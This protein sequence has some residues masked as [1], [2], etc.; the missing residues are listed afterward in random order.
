MT[1]MSFVK[2]SHRFLFLMLF[3]GIMVLSVRLNTLLA[4]ETQI[5]QGNIRIV[6]RE[7]SSVTQSHV[8]LGDISDIKANGFIKDVIEK[9][10]ISTSPKPGKI[11]LFSK[12]KIVSILRGQRYLPENIVIISPQQIY[13]KRLS[14]TI[15]K[16]T[17]TKFVDTR[18]RQFF[19]H[20]AYQLKILKVR[21]LNPY[22]QG[23]TQFRIDS[24]EM[25]DRNGKLSF[26]IDV[27]IDG[28]KE[29]RLSISGVVALY[30]K[31]LLAKRGLAKGEII[32]MEDV[33]SKKRNIYELRGDFIKTFEAIDGKVLKSGVRKGDVLKAGLL[34]DLPLVKKGDIIT[35]VVRNEN[36]LIV[37]SGISK[38]NGFENEWIK[39]ENLN[40]GRLVRGIIKGKSKVEVIY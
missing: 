15:S 35:L 22:P 19:N 13:V 28:T 29:D 17:I 25:V 39:V 32:T 37:T 12:N 26:F 11:K 20:K 9:I 4:D 33:Y 18:L 36:L 38:E 34:M 5:S 30:E 23:K 1:D 10:E 3:M 7:T 16:Q 6:I 24:D 8:F 21:G 40:S 14:Q 31:V 2:L 27:L